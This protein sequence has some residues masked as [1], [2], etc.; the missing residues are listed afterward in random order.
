MD[1]SDL[2]PCFSPTGSSAQGYFRHHH[3]V[4]HQH[5]HQFSS[6]PTVLSATE[7]SHKEEMM[8]ETHKK[9]ESD[10]ILFGSFWDVTN[11]TLKH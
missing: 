7:M 9:S 1:F 3:P 5:I 2:E 10:Y 8:Y 4:T 6:F 11:V